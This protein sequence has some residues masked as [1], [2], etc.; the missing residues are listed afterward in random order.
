LKVSSGLGSIAND[1]HAVA[2]SLLRR[3]RQED[4]ALGLTSARL[5]ALSV[6]VFDGPKTIGELAAMEQVS[7]PTMTRISAAL[8]KA[9]HV[10]RAKNPNDRR[11]VMLESTRSGA[12]LLEE[13][14]RRRVER[15]T[16]MLGELGNDDL[17]ACETALKALRRVIGGRS[18]DPVG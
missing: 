8:C 5:S 2:I 16:Q 14:K 12:R 4:D 10:R 15:V 1:L 11:Y 7:L 18:P 17:V 3:V 6:L 13:G 9:G